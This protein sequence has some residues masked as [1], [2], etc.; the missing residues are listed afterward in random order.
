MSYIAG[1]GNLH[2][3][4]ATVHTRYISP[5][6]QPT[7]TSSGLSSAFIHSKLCSITRQSK[8]KTGH[9]THAYNF[10]KYSP[11]F[12]ILSLADSAVNT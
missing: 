5:V 12:N 6:V 4:G 2:P 9:S 1:R 11:M 10:A 3:C 7:T 8:R